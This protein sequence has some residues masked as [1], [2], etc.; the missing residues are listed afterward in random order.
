MTFRNVTG[1]RQGFRPCCYAHPKTSAQSSAPPGSR[2]DDSRVGH[3]PR[4][5][6]RRSPAQGWSREVDVRLRFRMAVFAGRLSVVAFDAGRD[7]G[8]RPRGGRGLSL[9]AAPRQ[10][11]DPLRGGAPPTP[12]SSASPALSRRPRSSST[13]SGGVSHRDVLREHSREPAED[14]PDLATALLRR[15]RKEELSLSIF[16]SFVVA[17]GQRSVQCAASFGT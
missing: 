13:A 8:A 4:R 1:R 11:A 2:A 9:G 7:G 14:L 5:S 12:A 3:A 17:L 16:E 15:T 10:R 6:R